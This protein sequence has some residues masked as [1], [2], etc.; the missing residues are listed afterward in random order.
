M[1][2]LAINSIHVSY[3]IAKN[4]SAWPCPE[5]MMMCILK[6]KIASRY[7]NVEA[8]WFSP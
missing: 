6:R 8:L 4:S 3:C 5:P 2:R 7:Y 1:R